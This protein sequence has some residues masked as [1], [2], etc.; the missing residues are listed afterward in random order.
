MGAPLVTNAVTIVGKSSADGTY[1]ELAANA[2]GVLETVAPA[3]QA[4]SQAQTD[5]LDQVI[6]L[7]TAIAANSFTSSWSSMA[8]ASSSRGPSFRGATRLSI[9]M[10]V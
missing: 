6:T 8:S 3:A 5:R 4:Q 9:P 1:V 7:L 2:A 10:S